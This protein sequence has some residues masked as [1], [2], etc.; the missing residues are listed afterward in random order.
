VRDEE[1][2]VRRRAR[3]DGRQLGGGGAGGWRRDTLSINLDTGPL[4]GMFDVSAFAGS[5]VRISFDWIVPESFT[6]PAHAQLDDVAVI[7]CG[8]GIVQAGEQCD[9]GNVAPGDGCGATCAV[10][11]CFTCTGEPSVCVATTGPACED[12]NPCTTG[13]H[14]AAGVCLSGGPTV[15]PGCEVCR[16]AEG[17]VV[18]RRTGCRASLVPKKTQLLLIDKSPDKKDRLAW[19]WRN[20]AATAFTDFGDPRTSGD[21][22]LCVY[23]ASSGPASLLMRATAPAG[24]RCGTKPCWKARKGKSF[25]Y[26]DPGRTPDGL[27]GVQLKSGADGKAAITVG[28]SGDALPL[29]TLPLGLPITVQVQAGQG[30]CWEATY[31]TA[32]TKKNTSTT[33]N[34]RASAGP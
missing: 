2:T 26:A 12:G 15:C 6:G 10:E 25:V 33:F 30:P 19:K 9:D 13:D 7:G 18:G 16:P 8:D 34:G 1:P 4:S 11:Q 24:G 29:P 27:F 22:A 23:D 3:S 31:T 5:D 17:C 32:G 28:G 21:Y 14:C 20:G